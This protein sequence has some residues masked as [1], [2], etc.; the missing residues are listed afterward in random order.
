L[1]KIIY[2]HPILSQESPVILADYV[3]ETNGTGLV[4]NA[5]GFG[6]EDY[7]ACKKYNIHAYSPI[8]A[9]GKFTNE[10][11]DEELVGIFYD[12]ANEKII[13]KLSKANALL[14]KTTFTHS[15]ACD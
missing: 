2:K 5:P 6:I 14:K 11:K 9:Y 7:L 15:V 4:H 1:E 12:D 10:V 3:I 13:D 8:D